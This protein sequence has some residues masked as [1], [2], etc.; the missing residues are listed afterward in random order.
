[1]AKLYTGIDIGT[2]HLK[3]AVCGERGVSQVVSED[4]P[5]GLVRDGR[6]TSLETMSGIIKEAVRKHKI[7]SKNCVFAL[8]SNDV[9]TRR[10]AI[11]A[12]TV[13]ELNLNLPFEF[14]DYIAD[15]KD[16]YNFDYAVLGTKRDAA[17]VPVE[18]DILAAAAPVELIDACDRMLRRAGL[19]LRAA[20]PDIMAYANIIAE[21]EKRQGLGSEVVPAASPTD[22]LV[23]RDYCFV[24]IGHSGTKVYLFPQGRYEVTRM[25]EFG[26]GRLAVAVADYYS[27]DLGMAKTYLATDYEGAQHIQP[28]LDMYDRLGVE[29]A[30]IVSFFNFNYPQSQLDALHYCGRGAG[31]APLMDALRS[32]VS[33]NLVDISAVMP[34]SYVPPE[35]LRDCSAAVGVALQ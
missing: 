29:I 34:P 16:K 11:P 1:M 25:V 4:L 9:Y 30:R 17:G 28:C 10:I 12:M 24:D 5:D 22:R 15:D 14:K 6:I 31:V 33:I 13:E 23:S 21:H 27:V 19:K 18:M 26:M 35:S 2:D 7:S 8:H 32:H 3:M 20:A